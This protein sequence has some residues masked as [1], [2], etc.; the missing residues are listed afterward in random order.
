MDIVDVL[1]IIYSL[2]WSFEQETSPICME[3]ADVDG[4]GRVDIE[5]LVYLV[6]YLYD[7]GPEPV[8]CTN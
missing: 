2:Q 5:D 3:E 6:K 4:N 1:D 8:S 7:S